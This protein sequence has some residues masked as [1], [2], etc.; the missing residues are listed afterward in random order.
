M[1]DLADFTAIFCHVP[2]I[3]AHNQ[4]ILYVYKSF[5][6][7]PMVGACG[8][9]AQNFHLLSLRE[10]TIHHVVPN[11]SKVPYRGRFIFSQRRAKAKCDSAGLKGDK[12]TIILFFLYSGEGE[13]RF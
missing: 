4:A 9:V 11:S 5:G 13:R 10:S 1:A 6:R 8:K 2:T 12:K 7:R 3:Y